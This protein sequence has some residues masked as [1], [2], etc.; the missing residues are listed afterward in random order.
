MNFRARSFFER[1]RE[2]GE[3]RVEPTIFQRTRRTPAEVLSDRFTLRAR[4]LAVAVVDKF[5]DELLAAH[6]SPLFAKPSARRSARTA[7]CRRDFAVPSGTACSSAIWRYVK[8]PTS[9]NNNTSR[10]ASESESST[11]ETAS[12]FDCRSARSSL[13]A[14]AA[15]AA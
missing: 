14:I 8:P 6:G 5:L 12:N 1:A 3:I 10:W 13:A 4:K 2:P 7:K 15:I 11:A 9:F